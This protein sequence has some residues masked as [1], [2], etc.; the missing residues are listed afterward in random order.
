M[1]DDT[2]FGLRYSL[3]AFAGDCNGESIT[4]NDDT[5]NGKLQGTFHD[6]F[7]ATA[8]ETFYIVIDVWQQ[9]T[10]FFDVAG[11]MRRG[12]SACL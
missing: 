7:N 2:R 4:C 12:D 1:C 9:V 6:Q 3:H 5:T 8:G 11:G 10:M